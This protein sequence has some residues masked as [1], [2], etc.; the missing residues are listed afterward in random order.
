MTDINWAA[1]LDLEDVEALWNGLYQLISRHPAVRPLH[2][3]TDGAAV[4]SP[5]EINADLTQELFLELFQKQRFDHYVN[6]GYTSNEIENEIAHIELPNLVGSRLRKRY[7]ESFRMARRVSSLLKTSVRFCRFGVDDETD[8]SQTRRKRGRPPKAPRKETL[9]S[10]SAFVEDEAA[11]EGAFDGDDDEP[12]TVKTNGNGVRRGRMV[13]QIF[14]LREWPRSKAAG[15]SGHF[16]AR[17]KSV[18]VR[19]RDTRLVGRSGTSQLILSNPELE[20]LIVEVFIAI[21]SPSDVRTLRQ[22]V[23]SKIPLQD[24]NVASLDEEFSTG[25]SGSIL[26]RDPSDS[27]ETPEGLLLRGEQDKQAAMLADEFLTALRRAVNNNSRRFTRLLSTLWHCYY[28]PAGPSQ[29][30]IA[31]MLGVSDSLV[32]DN[33]RL[34]EYE[35]KKLRLSREDG[36]V[37]S[38]SLQRLISQTSAAG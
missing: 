25:T 5:M 29:L 1:V 30:E 10:N 38:E 7:P 32:S 12:A 24:Y 13:N 37:F 26:R 23:L 2:F 36:P 33:R 22:L 28:D 21:D 8:G 34:I 4:A 9:E 17:V 6:S 3:A 11:I 20:A 14:G 27:R 35:L 31:E 15:D 19:S 16:Q 18:P